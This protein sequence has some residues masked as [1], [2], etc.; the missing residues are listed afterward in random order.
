VRLKTKQPWRIG[1][2]GTW[3]GLSEAFA[4][5]QLEKFFGVPPA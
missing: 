5:Q 1:K 4:A 2:H 3:I